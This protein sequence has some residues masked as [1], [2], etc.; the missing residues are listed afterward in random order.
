MTSISVPEPVMSLAVAPKA[1]CVL[2]PSCWAPH[3]G[4]LFAPPLPFMV[5]P[6]PPLHVVG[7]FIWCAHAACPRFRSRRCL[8]CLHRLYCLY[9]LPARYRCRDQSANFSKALN[10]FTKEDPTFRVGAGPGGVLAGWLAVRMRS[11]I[12]RRAPCPARRQLPAEFSDW[13][14]PPLRTP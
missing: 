10:R 5:L 3:V 2:C 13:L 6:A 8:H 7:L 1:R 4:P 11:C 14:W 12:P 9:C